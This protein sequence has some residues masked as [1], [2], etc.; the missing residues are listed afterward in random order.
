MSLG[1]LGG[2][3]KAEGGGEDGEG[4]V[5]LEEVEA[6]MKGSDGEVINTRRGD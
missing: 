2:E 3:T 4:G 5:K 6:K 1:C